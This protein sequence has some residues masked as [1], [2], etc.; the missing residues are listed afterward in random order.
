MPAIWTPLNHSSATRTHCIEEMQDTHLGFILE[1]Y[2]LKHLKLNTHTMR[3]LKSPNKLNMGDERNSD[4]FFLLKKIHLWRNAQT[5][6]MCGQKKMQAMYWLVIAGY[7]IGIKRKYFYGCTVTS[8][9][10]TL[11]SG[12]ERDFSPHFPHRA[13]SY[14][15]PFC[16]N[17]LTMFTSH[18]LDSPQ[19]TI[20]DFSPLSPQ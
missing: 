12:L 8:M 10:W 9:C 3:C 17:T 15:V 14:S 2:T 7:V 16:I 4:M 18:G 1:I 6:N 5:F 20:L 19:I 13:W 11:F